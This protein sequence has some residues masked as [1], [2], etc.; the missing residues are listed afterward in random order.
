MTGLLDKKRFLVLLWAVLGGGL[1]SFP[2]CKEMN[3]QK[4]QSNQRK[5]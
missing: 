1:S 2:R 5:N 3:Q 4:T